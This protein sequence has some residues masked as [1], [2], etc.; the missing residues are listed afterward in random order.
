ME[1]LRDTLALYCISFDGLAATHEAW[2]SQILGLVGSDT[3]N[4]EDA[5]MKK[6]SMPLAD[7]QS[8]HDFASLEDSQDKEDIRRASPNDIH[9][10]AFDNRGVGRSS[11]PEKKSEYTT[12]IMALDAL[13]LMDHLGW[14]KAHVFGHSLG[15]MIACKLAAMFPDRIA[16][17]ALLSATGGGYECI[18]KLNWV[19]VSLAYRFWKAKSSEE[20]ALV[21][22]D[23]HYTKEYLDEMAGEVSRRQL[24]YKEYVRNI[25]V[26]GMQNIRG[27]NGQ[28]NA[29]WTHRV[30]S[31][32]YERLRTS[33]I[34]ISVIHG[35]GDVIAQVRHAR[36]IARNL[37]PAAR[38]L[39][40]PSG[41]LITHQHTKEVNQELMELIQAA[42][43]NLPHSEWQKDFI[44][45]EDDKKD[46][47]YRGC[48]AFMK[49]ICRLLSCKGGSLLWEKLRHYLTEKQQ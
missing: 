3:P 49:G 8:L 4:E 26:S 43:T 21:D 23:T 29:C 20:R 28:M 16:S 25:S 6:L 17:L 36:T 47:E 44:I 48:S 35:R 10:C 15:A 32:D 19:L 12:K 5:S 42:C 14:R 30:S 40:L 37:Y 39:E 31:E 41:H 45:H 13:D 46:E 34:L 38:L 33:S 27:Q 9:V 22:L 2:N 11:T 7:C 1:L 24:L 18:P